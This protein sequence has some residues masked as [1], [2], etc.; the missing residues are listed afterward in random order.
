VGEEI[1]QMIRVLFVAV[2]LVLVLPRASSASLFETDALA[3][4]DGLITLDS[5][6]GFEWLDLTFTANTSVVDLDAQLAADP[7]LSTF[8]RATAVEVHALFEE[9][10]LVSFGAHEVANIAAV[11]RLIS[12][13]GD[14][15]ASLPGAG[16]H[17]S[18]GYLADKSGNPLS[19]KLASFHTDL[20][21]FGTCTAYADSPDG[22][23]S[24]TFAFPLLGHYLVRD[25]AVG[26]TG[27]E[28]GALNF[29]P[30]AATVPEPSLLAL[31][32][33][34]LVVAVCRRRRT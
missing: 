3:V 19:T 18:I 34:G 6:T 1:S 33:S 7:F 23:A 13:L 2:C 29:D 27:R 5:E 12:L 31:L 9:A 11:T 26:G 24:D 32:G 20:F 14:T 28:P 30:C 8:R 21:A 4:G 10:G 22:E 15:W 16:R 25:G 17:G